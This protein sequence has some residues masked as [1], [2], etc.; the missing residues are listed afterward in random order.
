MDRHRWMERAG[1]RFKALRCSSA[2]RPAGGGR[3]P[4]TCSPTRRLREKQA[5]EAA[6]VR[7]FRGFRDTHCK[8]EVTFILQRRVINHLEYTSGPRSHV[9]R[10]PCRPHRRKS[11]ERRIQI[12]T[13]RTRPL[14]TLRNGGYPVQRHFHLFFVI[15]LFSL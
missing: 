15:L 2:L 10:Q 7:L 9:K 3:A 6:L 8:V 13:Q 1:R 11:T 12:T 5:C 4:R 14:V